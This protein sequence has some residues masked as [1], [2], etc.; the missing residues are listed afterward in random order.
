MKPFKIYVGY[1]PRDDLA[2]RAC[3][4]SLLKHTSIELQIIPLKD[5]E[6][7]RHGIYKRPYRVKE[8]G[9]MF[10]GVD[11]LP[12]STQFS[13]TR[14]AIPSI[15]DTD[16]WVLFCDA[17]FLWR[18]D[19]AELLRC[20]EDGKYLMCVQ[21]D[22]RPKE[23]TKFDGMAQQRYERK[24]WSSL[25]LMRP[26]RIGIPNDA[27]NEATGSYLHRFRFIGDDQLGALPP[28]WNW[29]EG[30]SDKAI[31]PKAVHF[32]RGTPDMLGNLP[33]DLEWWKAVS[34]WRPDMAQH[35][36]FPCA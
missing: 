10:D 30:W 34:D 7:R 11:G 14:F 1:D 2:F 26:K 12:F 31:T 8:S 36:A 6:L 25:M 9:Q 22:Y 20:A 27:L 23:E 17:D 15:D 16:D 3:V 21:H 28:E 35:G 29:L 4:S 18:A 13:F 19:V 24:N 32:T 33:Y 5:Y